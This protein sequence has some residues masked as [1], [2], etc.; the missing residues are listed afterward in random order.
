LGEGWN[1][2]WDAN[3]ILLRCDASRNHEASILFNGD[4]SATLSR[5][6]AKLMLV[7]ITPAEA[8]LIAHIRRFLDGPQ[9]T[10]CL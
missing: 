7:S 4:M 6:Q 9:V 3:A 10:Q 5:T 2:T 1:K 8:F